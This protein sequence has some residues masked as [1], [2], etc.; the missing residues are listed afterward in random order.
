MSKA[1]K[2]RYKGWVITH[3]PYGELACY[4]DDGTSLVWCYFGSSVA[5]IKQEIDNREFILYIQSIWPI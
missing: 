4:R 1:W 3:D 2:I 5:V